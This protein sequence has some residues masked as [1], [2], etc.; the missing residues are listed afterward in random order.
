M[1]RRTRKY[2]F[3][4]TTVICGC[5][6]FPHII[7][8][9][10]SAGL[11]IRVVRTCV[12]ASCLHLS[13]ILF[14]WSS[15]RYLHQGSLHSCSRDTYRAHWILRYQAANAREVTPFVTTASLRSNCRGHSGGTWN[16]EV[17]YAPLAGDPSFNIRYDHITPPPDSFLTMLMMQKEGSRAVYCTCPTNPAGHR[18]QGPPPPRIL[19]VVPGHS[20]SRRSR[21][22]FCGRSHPKIAPPAALRGN[23]AALWY[24][25]SQSRPGAPLFAVAPLRDPRSH[26]KPPA[27]LVGQVQYRATHS[28]YIDLHVVLHLFPACQTPPRL[29]SVL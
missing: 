27:G 21:P 9:Y 22:Y 19:A 24:G 7:D 20:G 23:R 15:S 6:I 29:P 1:V 11:D 28:L 12:R 8:A 2:K 5:A 16:P 17:V 13:C 14:C 18:S 10:R 25:W 4:A 26:P 3:V